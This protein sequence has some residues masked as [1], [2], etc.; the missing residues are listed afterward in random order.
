LL[1][2]LALIV[3]LDSG[4]ETLRRSTVAGKTGAL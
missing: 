2:G 1:L 3:R 4:R